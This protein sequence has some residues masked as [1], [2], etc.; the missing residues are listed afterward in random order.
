MERPIFIL[1][2]TKSGTTLLRSLFDGYPGLFTI[3]TETHFFQNINLWVDYYFRRTKPSNISFTQMKEN[4]FKWIEYRNQ[5]EHLLSDGFTKGRWD[6]NAFRKSLESQKISNYK[7]LSDLYVKALYASIYKKQM[8]ANYEF[9]EKSVENAE[10]VLEWNTLYPSARFIHI[11]RN[12]Y[13]N[14]VALRK[15]ISKHKFPFLKNALYAMHNSYYYLYK[16][17]KWINDY[18]VVKYEDLISGPKLVMEDI[19]NFLEIPFKPILLEPTLLGK[20]WQGNST[21]GKKFVGV[22]SENL[23]RWKNEI[24]SLEIN[25]INTWFD[26][27]LKDYQYERLTPKKSLMVPEK[28]ELFKRYIQNRLLWRFYN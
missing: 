9:I 25:M 3:P 15:Y 28:N 23:N 22:S 19:S 13:S 8:P 10:F 1:G 18:K 4:L 7:Q 21:S 20:K 17:S 27:I 12:P 6:L 14:L 26:F 11:V 5:K 24:T 2:C 16:N